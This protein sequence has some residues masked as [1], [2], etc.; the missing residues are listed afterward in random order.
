MGQLLS[1]RVH[2]V[3]NG[4]TSKCACPL[5]KNWPNIFIFAAA[6]TH[7][8]LEGKKCVAGRVTFVIIPGEMTPLSSHLLVPLL[9][10]GHIPLL[11]VL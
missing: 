5:G 1:V 11:N 9:Y 4:P 10:D 7:S 2:L 8:N 6:G 3:R